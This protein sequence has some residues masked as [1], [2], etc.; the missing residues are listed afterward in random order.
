MGKLSGWQS[1]YSNTGLSNGMPSI[2]PWEPKSCT[3]F[4]L[5]GMRDCPGW[6]GG[7]ME[8]RFVF[9]HVGVSTCSRRQPFLNSDA[10]SPYPVPYLNSF[11]K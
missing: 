11:N 7:G 5:E 6:W 1:Q 8:T 2:A 10:R 9:V 3:L 4:T